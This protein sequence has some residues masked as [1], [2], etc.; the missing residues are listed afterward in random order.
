MAPLYATLVS[1][2]SS[3]FSRTKAERTLQND[4]YIDD[5]ITLLDYFKKWSEIHK[6]PNVSAVTWKS[7]LNTYKRIK[8]YFKDTRLNK[9]TSSMYQEVI[10]NY[11]QT[12]SQETVERFNVHVKSA[13][14]MAVYEGLITRNFCTFAKVN[15]QNKGIE[16]ETKFLEIE[17]YLKLLEITSQK[18]EYQSY[19]ILYLIAVTGARFGECLGFT[20]DDIDNQAKN[21]AVNKTWD[22]HTNTGFKSTKTKSSIRKN[23]T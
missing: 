17:E 10:N 20:W 3:T 7:Y 15:S 9:I 8:L 16:T 1:F 14:S 23:S 18:L 6:K 5:K 11:A 13:V 4:V 19:F 21:I 12:H 22:Y 2:A